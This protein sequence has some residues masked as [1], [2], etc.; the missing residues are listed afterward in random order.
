MHHGV[1]NK[2]LE[3]DMSVV[4][5]VVYMFD[6]LETTNVIIQIRRS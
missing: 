3:L 1:N 5:G 2:G 6:E 4:L